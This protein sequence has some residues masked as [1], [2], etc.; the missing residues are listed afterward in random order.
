[1]FYLCDTF[2][3]VVKTGKNDT[4]Y[5]GRE[6]AD[7]SQEE[8]ELF[9]KK[10]LKIKNYKILKG[11]FPDETGRL[12]EKKQFKF[13]HIDVDTYQGAKDIYKWVWPKLVVGGIIIFDDYGFASTDGVM[14]MVNEERCKEDRVVIHNLN[15]HGIIIKTAI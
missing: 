10:V 14:K 13:C 9:F 7:S 4:Y 8:V 3:G 6:H 2:E 1:M 11:V 12:I 15:G 5:R